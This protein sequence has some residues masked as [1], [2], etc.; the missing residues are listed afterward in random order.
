MNC[1]E[2]VFILNGTMKSDEQARSSLDDVIEVLMKHVD[3]GAIRENLKLTPE[4]RLMKLQAR[5]EV[6]ERQ[7]TGNALYELREETISQGT[8]AEPAPDSEQDSMD[9]VIRVL[10]DEVDMTL[11]R[12][13]LRLTPH[14]RLQKL[15]DFM[16]TMEELHRAGE[17]SR[18]Q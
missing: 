2:I 6:E 17:R 10:A 5:L 14:Q 18:T 7:Q 8:S 3:L 16:N 1:T 4:Q 12:E 15:Q 11:I 9:L 13:N